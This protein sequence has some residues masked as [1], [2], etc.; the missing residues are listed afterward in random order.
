VNLE[1]LV[2]RA[3]MPVIAALI[4]AGLG[5]AVVQTYV[6]ITHD[7]GPGGFTPSA[8]PFEPLPDDGPTTSTT[9]L[10]ITLPT[11]P[12]TIPAQTPTTTAGTTK[13]TVRA[14][15]RTTAA[16]AAAPAATTTT[17]TTVDDHGG[18]GGN[19]G[20]GGPPGGDD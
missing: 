2:S 14:T 18:R 20:R 3:G 8:L 5:T 12:S 1:R 15:T 13:T 11:V 17:S 19:S 6:V 10:L 9:A 4:A 7:K 16:P